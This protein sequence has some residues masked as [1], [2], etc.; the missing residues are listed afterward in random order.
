VT[1]VGAARRMFAGLP[2]AS[3]A[4]VNADGSPH[5]VPLWFVWPEDAVY[6][7]TRR[8]SRTW[9]NAGREPR[10]CVSID[11]GRGWTELAG[12]SIVGRAEPMPA[13]HPGMRRPISAWHEKYRSLLSG[14]GFAGFAEQVT[15]LA[16]L[17]VVP[18][19]IRAWDHA[20]H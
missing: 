13:E 19:R 18:D 3:V 17:R 12:V 20:R 4:T 8:P 15:S 9:T 5:V 6:V 10:V 2:V 1:D 16:F 7:S 14:D 11:V